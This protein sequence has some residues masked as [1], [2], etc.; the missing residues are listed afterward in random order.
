MKKLRKHNIIFAAVSGNILEFYDFTLY[1]I[2]API[3]GRLF[4]PEINSVNAL[5]AVFGVY[6]TGF[7][8]RPLGSILFGYIG[9]KVGRKTSLSLTIGLMSIPTF[10]FAICPTY[11]H[12][13]IYAPILLTVFRIIQGLCAGGEFT[14]SAVFVLEHYKDSYLGLIGGVLITS[15]VGGAFLATIVGMIG[16]M[17]NFSQDYFWRLAF[18]AGSFI[19][20]LSFY[21]R[22][23]LSE[24]SSFMTLD[25]K[26][27]IY[28]NPI[29]ESI[30]KHKLAVF[31]IF[32]VGALNGSV[33]YTI[34]G[35]SSAY[36]S[37][38]VNV[39]QNISMSS[40]MFG[41]LTLMILSPVFG[42]ISDLI[43]PKK[44]MI[45]AASL[46]IFFS[47]PAFYLY[48]TGDVFFIYLTQIILGVLGAGYVG[49]QH[50]FSIR[51]FPVSDRYT[52]ISLGYS[53][54]MAFLGGT[55]PFM[56]S[57]AMR[58]TG[59]NIMASMWLLI[60]AIVALSGILVSFRLKEYKV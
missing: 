58:L 36:L 44:V 60:S 43:T 22:R 6:A 15:C 18:L 37:Q 20:V 17:L 5:I 49:P 46:T 47:I 41:L 30:K 50:S 32:G 52:G 12:I 3:I 23:K 56:A 26:K 55:T 33:I 35:Y 45:Y 1:A 59:S 16:S 53:L 10:L 42:Y 19:G 8:A 25:L 14:G 34:F 9:D 11:F 2:F 21:I 7:I 39:P 38:V 51:L 54:G 40:S 48:N 4:F 27:R 13:G 24:T 31:C 29:T 57:L 28:K